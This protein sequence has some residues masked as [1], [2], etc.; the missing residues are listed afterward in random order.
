MDKKA[1]LLEKRKKGLEN[2]I[3]GD[4]KSDKDDDRKMP[5]DRDKMVTS[6]R[7]I[8]V[9]RGSREVV[10]N[11]AHSRSSQKPPSIDSSVSHMSESD[12]HILTGKISATIRDELKREVGLNS[13]SDLRRA[14]T[15]KMDRYL[16]SEL[17]THICKICS[18]LM[19]SPGHTPMLLFPCGH[20][21]VLYSTIVVI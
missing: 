6:S 19:V 7:E 2:W 21:C 15:E 16:E 9:A 3:G 5:A 13:S 1:L 12:I 11:R 20:R 18:T 10:K 17:H 14:M 4:K 8:L